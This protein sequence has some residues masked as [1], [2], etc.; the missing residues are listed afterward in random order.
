MPGNITIG[1]AGTAGQVSAPGIKNTKV[2]KHLYSTGD[3]YVQDE[4]GKD[5]VL[6][7]GDVITFG[8]FDTAIV[9]NFDEEATVQK[10]HPVSAGCVRSFHC[11]K[12]GQKIHLVAAPV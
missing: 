12:T 2:R 1:T 4:N 3:G 6:A 9:V 7:F 10:G 11:N 5:V 8:N